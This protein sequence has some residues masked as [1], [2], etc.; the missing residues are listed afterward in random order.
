MIRFYQWIEPFKRSWFK[1]SGLPRF[2]SEE[3]A[4]DV[5]GWLIVQNPLPPRL[6]PPSLI[7]PLAG[8]N[9]AGRVRA[10]RILGRIQD[11]DP[12]VRDHLLLNLG[13]TDF[14]TRFAAR[15]AI[16]SRQERAEEVVPLVVSQLLA[17]S[18]K[19]PYG[20]TL[21]LLSSYG[22]EA[23][24]AS[25]YLLTWLKTE[26]PNQ[27]TS[28]LYF[29]GVRILAAIGR[30]EAETLPFIRQTFEA[31][32]NEEARVEL[33]LTLLR[34]D[35]NQV[36]ALTLLTNKLEHETSNRGWW[37]LK[38]ALGRA[39]VD[40]RGLPAPEVFR[41]APFEQWLALGAGVEWRHSSP[42]LSDCMEAFGRSPQPLYQ[43]LALE[44]TD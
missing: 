37:E 31:V 27:P 23:A 2:V 30:N 7:Q 13:D 32:T 34:L 28:S 41:A 24:G 21:E 35:V 10:I 38:V 25:L 6:V 12:W 18:T 9:V 4:R 29:E 8:S 14:R 43:G 26:D 39:G 42:T 1:S 3:E 15:Q 40:V 22:P 16:G 19:P 33:A 5:A 20:E 11:R 36:E 17:S 44:L